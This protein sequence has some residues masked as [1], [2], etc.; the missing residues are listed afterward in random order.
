[1]NLQKYSTVTGQKDTW[2]LIINESIFKKGKCHDSQINQGDLSVSSLDM[3][4][5]NIGYTF[6]I[7]LS[8]LL[9]IQCLLTPMETVVKGDGST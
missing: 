5:L 3:P 7:K 9:L 1:M 4:S 8:H 2:M 6:N